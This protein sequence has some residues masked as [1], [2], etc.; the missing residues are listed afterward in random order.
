MLGIDLQDKIAIVTGSTQGIGLGI[1]RML[2]KAG[3][4][5]AGCGID[6][7][8]SEKALHFKS[9]VEG[10]DRAV[11]YQSLDIKREADILAF[12]QNI[13]SFFGK[14]DILI[15]NAGKNMFTAPEKCNTTFWDDDNKLNLRSHWLISKAC[16]EDLKKTNGFIL[17][18]T[19]NH[20]YYTL[21]NCFPYNVSKAGIIGMVKALAI[22]WGPKIRVMGMAPG[23]IQTEGT[24][25][26]FASF[27]NPT[28]KKAEILNIHPSKSFGN[29]DDIGAFCAF[30]ASNYASFI[31]GT[32]YLI[33]G[34][35][36]AMMQ[37]I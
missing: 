21:P 23:F 35:R 3:C 17:I 25:D 18:M 6:K 11:F 15:S 8:D 31:T 1:A 10:F 22:E 27:P 32:T 19:S 26:W 28:A 37:D 7:E 14:I 2:A 34:G 30:L 24:D 9:T 29:V 20:A 33:D 5:I 16:Y 13:K 12:V 4:H 36:S